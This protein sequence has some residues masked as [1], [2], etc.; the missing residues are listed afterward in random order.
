MA[1]RA[2]ENFIKKA[3]MLYGDHYWYES[4]DYID[5]YTPI[6]VVC[7]KHGLFKITPRSH[8][9]G[10][11]CSKCQFKKFDLFVSKAIPKFNGKYKYE[12]F[13]DY[14]FKP[15]RKVKITCPIHG[16]FF[17]TT[18]NHVRGN[19]C[20]KCS[21]EEES[22]KASLGYYEFTKRCDKVHNKKYSYSLVEYKNNRS[23][24]EIICPIHGSFFQSPHDHLNGCGCPKCKGR[25]K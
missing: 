17:Q 2:K 18:Y 15:N 20:P 5:L 12:L 19:G 11:A 21:Y 1:E 6:N 4:I 8:L 3:K 7:R 14:D 24:V 9:K 13:S 16:D 25:N 10:N 22:E 23:K